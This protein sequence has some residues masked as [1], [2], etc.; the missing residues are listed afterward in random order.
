MKLSIFQSA[1]MAMFVG[2]GIATPMAETEFQLG[3]S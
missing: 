2:V 3:K 1:V